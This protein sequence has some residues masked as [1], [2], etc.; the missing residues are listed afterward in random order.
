MAI[1]G[2]HGMRRCMV[3]D[4]CWRRNLH[5]AR[6]IRAIASYTVVALPK[7]FLYRR[8]LPAVVGWKT[9]GSATAPQIAAT[10]TRLLSGP[11]AALER[12][13]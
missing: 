11:N 4:L 6:H 5:G 2:Q 9:G 1:L 3:C 7:L 13:C 8:R 12:A 10:L